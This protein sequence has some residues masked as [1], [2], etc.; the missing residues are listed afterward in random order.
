[1]S[2]LESVGKIKVGLC[3]DCLEPIYIAPVWSGYSGGPVLVPTMHEDPKQRHV[4]WIEAGPYYLRCY[5][6]P[7][8]IVN[9]AGWG[10]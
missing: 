10:D 2:P 7:H 8:R 9:W 3:R 6:R 4:A 5:S 1:M